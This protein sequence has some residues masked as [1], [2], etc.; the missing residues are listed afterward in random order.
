M[1]EP[2]DQALLEE[3]WNSSPSRRILNGKLQR[4]CAGCSEWKYLFQLRRDPQTRG[5]AGSRCNV[6][7]NARFEA[8][9]MKREQLAAERLKA[10]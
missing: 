6:C 9:K 8:N 3:T 10:G 1:L 2:E 7:E 5:G 4:F